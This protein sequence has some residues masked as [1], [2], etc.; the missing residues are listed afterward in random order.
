MPE[1]AQLYDALSMAEHLQLVSRLQG[2]P[3]EL[4]ARRALALMEAFGLAERMPSRIGSLSKGQRQKVLIASA[5]LHDP[6]I[7]FLDEPLSG[8]DVASTILISM[9]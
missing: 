4:G 1:D 6:K 2:L 8:L 7:L 3:D 5:L 9:R